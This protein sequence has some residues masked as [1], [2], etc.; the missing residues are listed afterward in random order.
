[1]AKTGAEGFHALVEKAVPLLEFVLK[2]EAARYSVG[3]AEVQARALTSGLRLLAKTENSVI[4]REAARLFSGWIRVDPDIIFVEL[5]KTMR[6]G[7]TTRSTTGTI[8]R[9]ASGQVRLEREALR[10]ALQQQRVV[11]ARMEDVSTDF[12]SVPA[13]RTIWAALLKGTDPALLAETLEED[14]ARRIATQLAVEPV[15]IDGDIDDE[16][17]EHLAIAVFS[18]LKEFVLSREIEQLTPQLQRLNPLENPK[19]HDEL[20]ARLLELQ[21]Q[22]RELTQ[23]GEGDE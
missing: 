6:T 20:F 14:D 12:F 8:L 23:M 15:P 19:E 18:R 13:H 17:V 3:D 16:A 7:T 1:V 10:L 2:R 11:K 21:R 22:K 9:R 4:R 5:E